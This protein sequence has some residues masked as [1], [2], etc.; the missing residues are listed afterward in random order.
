M[1]A[2]PMELDDEGLPFFRPDPADPPEA[3]DVASA[4]RLEQEAQLSEDHG[5]AGLRKGGK[6]VR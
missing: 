2:D 4:L 1:E 6:A 5:R 3:I